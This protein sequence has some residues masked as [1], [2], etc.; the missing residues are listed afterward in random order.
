[1]VMMNLVKTFNGSKS[2][3]LLLIYILNNFPINLCKESNG[4]STKPP[5]TTKFE[6]VQ[7][8]VWQGSHWVASCQYDLWKT[9]LPYAAVAHKTYSN[10]D[11]CG[12][13]FKVEQVDKR[14]KVYGIFNNE[15][16]DCPDG[17]L[18]MDKKLYNLMMGEKTPPGKTNVNW[19]F[20][21]CKEA[22]HE[23]K[24]T[25]SSPGRKALSYSAEATKD[26]NEFVVTVIPKVGSSKDWSE[27]QVA[28]ATLQ[29]GKVEVKLGGKSS[30]ISTTR[31]NYNYFSFD[32]AP[33]DKMDIK[34]TCENGVVLM[35]YGIKPEFG[36]NVHL[37]DNCT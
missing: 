10:A 16:A 32:G 15:C 17:A 29:I 1:M 24:K 8:T 3:L 13:C 21:D 36:S 25:S 22:V 35:A 34:I 14:K 5:A 26:H 19:E 27:F 37:R 33:N 9:S 4:A 2:I 23:A 6:N 18:D 20:V 31:K 7:A 30:Y 11:R 28:G 12:A